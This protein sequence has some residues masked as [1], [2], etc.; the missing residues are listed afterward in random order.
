LRFG[1]SPIGGVS[2]R[3][4][5]TQSRSKTLDGW[6]LRIE[7]AFFS[8][9]LRLRES[10]GCFGCCSVAEEVQRT[11][12]PLYEWHSRTFCSAL[13]S[14]L[15]PVFPQKESPKSAIRAWHVIGSIA[16]LVSRFCADLAT[17]RNAA[18]LDILQETC[19]KVDDGRA[20]LT[21][22]SDE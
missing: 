22:A 18:T 14:R 10:L 20:D 21:V 8:A 19:V 5:G 1:R 16:F 13:V 4:A 2:R 6:L 7:P 11:R 17:K 3:A 12:S 9:S 15:Q